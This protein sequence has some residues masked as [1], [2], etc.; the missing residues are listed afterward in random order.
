[1]I[2][3]EKPPSGERLLLLA[4]G[5]VQRYSI[6]TADVELVKPRSRYHNVQENLRRSNGLG[7]TEDT[8]VG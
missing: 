3:T 6:P 1:M 4:A 7:V 8:G 2:A 5:G